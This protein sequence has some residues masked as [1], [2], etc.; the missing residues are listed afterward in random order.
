[1]ELDD[2]NNVRCE[3][4]SKTFE[5][6]FTETKIWETLPIKQD[7]GSVLHKAVCVTNLEVRLVCNK[8]GLE[9]RETPEPLVYSERP[10][11]MIE[12]TKANGLL[13]IQDR[14]KSQG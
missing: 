4:F 14:T 11:E 5:K 8:C 10:V 6:R 12:G 1:M 13:Q 7:D 2:K 3:C 9:V